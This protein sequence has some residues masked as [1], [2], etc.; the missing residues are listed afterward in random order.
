[1]EKNKNFKCKT[2][3]PYTLTSSKTHQNYIAIELSQY[4]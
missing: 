1:M 3:I 2:Q 4:P